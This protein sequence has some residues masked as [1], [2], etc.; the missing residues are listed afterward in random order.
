M[1]LKEQFDSDEFEPESEALDLLTSYSCTLQFLEYFQNAIF[2]NRLQDLSVRQV[3]MGFL[4][5]LDLINT[6]HDYPEILTGKKDNPNE[7]QA[8]RN[9]KYPYGLGAIAAYMCLNLGVAKEI[10]ADKIPNKNTSKI[11]TDWFLDEFDILKDDKEKVLSVK[12]V[13]TR[14]RNAISHHNFKLRIPDS[15]LNEVDLRDKI[16]V[17]FYD[18]DGK[19]GNDFYAKAS[20]R[21]VEKVMKKI[22]HTEYVFHNCPFF[23]YD[24]LNSESIVEYVKTCFT[25]FCRSYTSR[26]LK[27]EGIEML[28][29][30]Q[31]YE[32]ES[33]SGFFEISKSDTVKYKVCFSLN[34]VICNDYFIDI[35]FFDKNN[36]YFLTIEDE[37]CYLGEYP[38]EWLLHDSRSPLCRLDKKIKDII[39][40]TLHKPT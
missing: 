5:S 33:K 40:S 12:D 10:V 27:F 25:H 23:E 35:P 21:V 18:T 38:M 14:L 13:I 9:L 29:P 15:K 37:I 26:G 39:K 31:A 16:E 8:I 2:D 1:K 24:E 17:S 11:R 34:K 30:F 32:I 20:F 28:D 22:H 4:N 7:M 19:T 36:P 3:Y 6:E